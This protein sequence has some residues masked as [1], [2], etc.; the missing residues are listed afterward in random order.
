MTNYKL[1]LQL[2]ATGE[3]LNTTTELSAEMKTYVDEYHTQDNRGNFDR[4]N[5]LITSHPDL[6]NMII[7]E[8]IFKYN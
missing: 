4:A 5:Q 7:N 3:N 6:L 1:N 8:K 2:F